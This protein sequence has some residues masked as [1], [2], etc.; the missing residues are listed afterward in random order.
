MLKNA[1]KIKIQ[2]PDNI[3]H[4]NSYELDIK[5]NEHKCFKRMNIKSQAALYNIYKIK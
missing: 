2:G 4:I 5:V 3:S 1:K